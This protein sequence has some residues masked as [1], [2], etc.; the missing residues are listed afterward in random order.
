MA[1]VGGDYDN[2]GDL[3]LFVANYNQNNFLYQN[4][5]NRSN[6]IDIRPTGTVSNTAAIGAKVKA[7]ATIKGKPVWQMLEHPD[8]RVI[9]VKTASM[10]NSAWVMQPLLIPSESNGPAASFVK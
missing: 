4:N 5:S 8:K 6:W 7:K 3:D 9:R 10:P 1:A 2:D